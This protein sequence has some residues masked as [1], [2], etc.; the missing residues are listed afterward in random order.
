MNDIQLLLFFIYAISVYLWGSFVVSLIGQDKLQKSSRAL[1]IGEVLLVGGVMSV[2]LQVFL[3]V[4]GLYNTY[5]IWGAV[6]ASYFLL[7]SRQVRTIAYEGLKIEKAFNIANIIFLVFIGVFFLR[8]FYFL[9]DC[10]SHSTYLYAQKLWLTYGTSLHADRGMDQRVFVPHFESVPYALGIAL[11][12]NETIFAQCINIFWRIIALLLV[13]GYTGHCFKNKYVALA[14]V[15]MVMFDEHFFVS[16]ANQW[17]TI[18]GALIAF[19]FAFAYSLWEVRLNS[20]PQ[21][22][23]LALVYLVHLMACKY[24]MVFIFFY[25]LAMTFL[26][27]H[28]PLALLGQIIKNRKQLIVLILTIGFSSLWYIKNY[29]ATGL[30]TFPILAWKFGTFGW[31]PEMGHVFMRAGR[32]LSLAEFFKYFNFMF[33]WPGINPLKVVCMFISLAPFMLFIS[34]ARKKFEQERFLHLA[35]WMIVT[36]LI[37]MGISLTS[38]QD[39]R[40]YRYGIAVF[41]FTSIVTIEFI[42]MNIL[43][44]RQRAVFILLVLIFSLAECRIIFQAPGFFQFPSVKENVQV[45]FNQIHLDDIVSKYYHR[46]IV[47]DNYFKEHPSTDL[48]LA[49]EMDQLKWV[50]AF[51]IPPPIKPQLGLLNLTTTVIN[52]D[53]Y[54]SEELVVR[55]LKNYGIEKIIRVEDDQVTLISLEEF[56]SQAVKIDRFPKKIRFDYGFPPEIVQTGL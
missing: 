49:W 39:P 45:L 13:Y 38:H 46:N 2:G 53:S 37:A 20:E 27:P 55:D 40:Y 17:S 24:Q 29:F 21:R 12:G 6:F 5:W 54:R 18:N 42:L 3:S 8:N 16:G 19:L 32:G 35:Y 11:F 15:F 30:A 26:I 22:L 23:L 1:Y 9:I 52:W 36:V 51:L 56:A 25:F 14:A 7:V 28:K 43:A 48:K 31:T 44:I 47:I 34:M 33:I 41:A 10:D 4:V 50:S